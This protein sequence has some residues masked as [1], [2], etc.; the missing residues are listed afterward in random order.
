MA[1]A[2]LISG[3]L[4][5]Q[6]SIYAT[7]TPQPLTRAQLTQATERFKVPLE[8]LRIHD[9]FQT[10]LPGTSSSN[11]L[12]LAG[13]TFGTNA[14]SLQTADLKAAGSTTNYARFTFN[15]PASYVA[16]QTCQVRVWGNMKTTVSDTAATVDIE[17]YRSG[18]DASIGSDLCATAAQSINSLTVASK[19]FTI[20]AAS[21]LPG[22]TIDIRLALLVNDAATATAVIGLVGGIELLL[23]TKG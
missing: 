22:D 6:G 5:V 1:I 15:L 2:N 16:G 14:P 20:T 3:D 23:G 7:G 11:D 19:D 13:G 10:A 17:A 18:D 9:A 21:L 12:G 8:T 4:M